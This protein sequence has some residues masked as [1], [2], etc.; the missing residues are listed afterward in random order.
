MGKSGLIRAFL[1]GLHYSGLSALA[2]PRIG[3][4]GAFLMLHRVRDE[5]RRDFAPNRFLSVSPKFL[6]ELLSE[7]KQD[8]FEFVSIDEA[9]ERIKSA[10]GV[11]ERPFLSITLDDA[12][13][14][15]LENAAPIFRAHRVPYTIYVPTALVEG[16]G[17]IWWEDLEA[18]IAARDH[19][20]MRSPDGGVAFDLSTPARKFKA[21]RELMEFLQVHVSEQ[22]QRELVAEL[23]WQAG[24]DT[25]SHVRESIMDWN[26]IY[27]LSRDPLCT[28]G[29][30]TVNHYAVARL[31][32][33]Q[34]IAEMTEGARVIGMETGKAPLHFAYPYGFPSAAGRRDFALAEKCGFQTAVTTRHGVIFPEHRDHLHSLPRVS[35]NGL[36]QRT[37]YVRALL[38][39]LPTLL[40]NRG[41]RL[42]VA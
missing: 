16:H 9:M 39:G 40:A 3:A 33:K 17:R 20:V 22:E 21:F 35:I 5:P 4:I 31:S 6:D 36:F 23:A 32:E 29:A 10:G 25:E 24:I 15:N 11:P 34:A 28:I 8:G 18:A 41:Q 7:L 1:N 14:D 37:R 19:I 27:E 30:H 26:Q 42:D 13:C 38:S 2:Q 12:Y